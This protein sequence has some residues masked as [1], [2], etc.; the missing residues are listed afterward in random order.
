MT[1]ELNSR[2][3]SVT[4]QS[5]PVISES[6][7]M[8]CQVSIWLS[9][10]VGEAVG[11]TCPPSRPVWGNRF[12][13]VLMTQSVKSNLHLANIC[14]HPRSNPLCT[15]HRLLVSL[16]QHQSLV[17]PCVSKALGVA[18]TVT[19]LPLPPVSGSRAIFSIWKTIF[20]LPFAPSGIWPQL[21]TRL[22]V[23]KMSFSPRV[24]HCFWHS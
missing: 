16:G 9:H 15:L 18:L 3:E 20:C 4:W 1:V 14:W 21:L 17:P 6:A 11:G 24:V 23:A 2:T 22:D 13:N 10:E 5:S 12:T 8:P 7:W 19:R